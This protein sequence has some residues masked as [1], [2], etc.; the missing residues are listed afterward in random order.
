MVLQMAQRKQKRTAAAALEH[1][2]LNHELLGA[3]I[4]LQAGGDAT[5]Q[6]TKPTATRTA[7]IAK[8][9]IEEPAVADIG[10]T[11]TVKPKRRSTRTTAVANQTKASQKPV[12][13]VGLRAAAGNK[14]SQ[15]TKPKKRPIPTTTVAK[16]IELNQKLAVADVGWMADP[17]RTEIRWLDYFDDGPVGISAEHQALHK[18]LHSAFERVGETLFFGYVVDPR[19]LHKRFVVEIMLDGV[20]AKLLRAEQ[21]DP[22]LRNGGFGD[23]CYAF[24]FVAKPDWLDRHHVVEARIA[25][26]GD[27]LGEAILL[28]ASI[29]HDRAQAPI[30]AVSWVGGVRLSGWVRDDQNREPGVRAFDGDVLLAET[31]PDRWAHIE[32]ET[33]C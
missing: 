33:N 21:Y 22:K 19:E 8:Q 30:G 24:E 10:L 4:S 11:A 1:P 13:D 16:Q 32:S 7:A 31:Q 6:A 26:T 12:A 9:T 14:A 27:R 2:K 29:S 20:P 3:S 28:S 17:S 18:R 5:S 23:G 25:N 15:T